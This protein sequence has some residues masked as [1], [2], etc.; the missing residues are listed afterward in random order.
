MSIEEKNKKLTTLVKPSGLTSAFVSACA[1]GVVLGGALGKYLSGQDLLMQ[2]VFDSHLF[3]DNIYLKHFS[4]SGPGKSALKNSY[5]AQDYHQTKSPSSYL[6]EW[7]ADM[8]AMADLEAMHAQKYFAIK[9]SLSNGNY[10]QPVVTAALDA[11]Q[12]GKFQGKPL[13]KISKPLFEKPYQKPTFHSPDLPID[14]KLQ[15]YLREQDMYPAE[16]VGPVRPYNNAQPY[17]VVN[18]G[19]DDPSRGDTHGFIGLARRI[20]EKIGAKVHVIDNTILSEYGSKGSADGLVPPVLPLRDYFERNGCPDFYLSTTSPGAVQVMEQM[21][22]GLAVL[23][24]NENIAAYLG[25]RTGVFRSHVSHHLTREGLTHEGNRFA[26]EFAELPRPFIGINL[27]DA[28]KGE[29]DKAIRHLTALKAAYGEATFFICGTRRTKDDHFN[30]FTKELQAGL[31]DSGRFPVVAF[32]YRE[33]FENEGAENFWN[34]YQGMLDQ[35]DHLL[36]IGD[37]GSILSECLFTGKALHHTTRLASADIVCLEDCILGAPLVTK[38]I[39]PPDVTGEIASALIARHE[40]HKHV[41]RTTT[42]LSRAK[43][44]VSIS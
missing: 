16:F 40:Q 20:G 43:P 33:H 31:G 9:E 26:E 21:G 15:P 10:N 37:S 41:G 34:I 19:K 13:Q 32:N 12:S 5:F 8:K 2:E 4:G 29:R 6:D 11:M 17:V 25:M 38:K 30:S 18:I 39:T 7:Q 44:F 3:D 28:S 22:E 23:S 36:Q 27:V 24:Y 1:G 14:D 35:S 42:G